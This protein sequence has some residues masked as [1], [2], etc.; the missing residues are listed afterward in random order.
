MPAH[1]AKSRTSEVEKK[2]VGT[3]GNETLSLNNMG[4]DELNSASICG[5]ACTGAAAA[6]A[7]SKHEAS[8]PLSARRV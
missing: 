2:H 5:T 6:A 8:M 3:G 7:A 4:E 1:A